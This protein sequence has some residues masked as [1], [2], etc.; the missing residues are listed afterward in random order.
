MDFIDVRQDQM[1]VWHTF[2][3]LKKHLT[4]IRWLNARFPA[5]GHFIVFSK[6]NNRIPNPN[7]LNKNK[8]NTKLF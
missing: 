4:Q 6:E 5:V 1:K 8:C 3:L 7:Q 2:R